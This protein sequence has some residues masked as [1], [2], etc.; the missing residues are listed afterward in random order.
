MI[1]ALD[2]FCLD[3]PTYI[4]SA[5]NTLPGS[6]WHSLA[7][8]GSSWLLLAPT[9]SS[10]LLVAAP[11]LLLASPGPSGSFL[12][13]PA[14]SLLLLCWLLLPL[15]GTET[16]CKLSCANIAALLFL[17][18]IELPPLIKASCTGAEVRNALAWRRQRGSEATTYY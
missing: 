1:V 5:K 17:A 10:W 4:P 18:A 14:S 2:Q 8:S 3:A 12:V 11:W 16:Q 9:G 13:P 7:P 6:F 15:E